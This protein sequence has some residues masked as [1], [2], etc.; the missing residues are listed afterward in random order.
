M[1][2]TL[3]DKLFEEKRQ[4]KRAI[5]DIE[6]KVYSIAGSHILKILKSNYR[7]SGTPVMHYEEIVDI[8]EMEEPKFSLS[9]IKNGLYLLGKS[10][11]IDYV[12]DNEY[13]Y[14]SEIVGIAL[15]KEKK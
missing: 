12:K 7:A 15:R 3:L 9:D 11:K 1:K 6:R 5:G 8:I 10:E 13:G 4:L 2:K 14:S